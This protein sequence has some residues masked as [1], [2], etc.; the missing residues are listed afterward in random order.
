MRE[1]LHG[2]GF[3]SELTRNHYEIDDGDE[4]GYLILP[5]LNN[6]YINGDATGD[7]PPTATRPISVFD[8]L[9]HGKKSFASQGL[10]L[11]RFSTNFADD[12]DD[13]LLAVLEDEATRKA[14]EEL[15]RMIK[16]DKIVAKLSN[17]DT[18]PM[19]HLPPSGVYSAIRFYSNIMKASP[20]FLLAPNFWP[21]QT[22][23][24][25]M[26]YL[27]LDQPIGPKTLQLLEDMGYA[28]ENNKQMPHLELM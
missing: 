27:G 19:Q 22:L 26:K 18:I 4:T 9:L 6:E 2:M 5:S 8:S 14:G 28:T 7:F 17:G 12:A 25:E 1:L 3:M 13:F 24:S 23:N 10:I 16:N 15:D 20:E 21:G 11:S